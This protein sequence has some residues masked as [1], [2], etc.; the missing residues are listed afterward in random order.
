MSP[1]GPGV[2]EGDLSLLPSFLLGS[3]G[4][5]AAHSCP[6]TCGRLRAGRKALRLPVADANSCP[7]LGRYTQVGCSHGVATVGQKAV[8]SPAGRLKMGKVCPCE[9]LL[10]HKFH[11]RLRARP[12]DEGGGCRPQQL[13]ACAVQQ[14]G[15][16]WLQWEERLDAP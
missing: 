1:V 14:D 15:Q 10:G 2:S 7:S 8:V 11:A 9:A 4:E 13:R 3:H 16:P 12:G 5:W 6:G